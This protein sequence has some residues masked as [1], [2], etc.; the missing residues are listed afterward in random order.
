MFESLNH[1]AKMLPVYLLGRGLISLAVIVA[2]MV[3]TSWIVAATVAVGGT[4]LRGVLRQYQESIYEQELVNLYRDDIAGRLGIAPAEVTRAHLPEAAQDNDIIAQ[5]IERQHSKSMISFLTSV[6]AGV[7]TFAMVGSIL[8][9]ATFTEYFSTALD[10]SKTTSGILSFFSTGI[11]AGTTGLIAH[12]GL[13]ALIGAG[14]GVAKPSAHDMIVRIQ[15]DVSEGH[16]ISPQRAFEVIVVSNPTLDQKIRKQFGEPYTGMTNAEQVNAIQQLGRTQEM[17]VLAYGLSTGAV[18]PGHLAY[19]IGDVLPE[20]APKK[21]KAAEEATTLD[22]PMPSGERFVAKL[23][24]APRIQGR[25]VEAYQAEN[26]AAL[27]LGFK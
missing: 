8:P 20:R 23:G 6:I 1:F 21:G 25:F 10:L 2:S 7:A 15:R 4:V 12:D 26:A 24:R 16:T 3:S 19:M 18:K 11:I 17:E 9:P 22:L 14:T 27:T 13:E 5:A